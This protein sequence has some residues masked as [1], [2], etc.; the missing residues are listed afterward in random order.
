MLGL[1]S[2]LLV[3][4]LAIGCGAVR[5]LSPFRLGRRI[6]AAGANARAAE[7]SGVPVAASSSI[8]HML[9]GLLA[10]IGGHDG[11]R[12]SWRSD[13]GVGRRRLAAALLPRA[14]ARRHAAFGRSGRGGRDRARGP[15]GDDDPQRAPGD[16]DRQLLAPA[17]PRR[18]PASR[19]ARSIAIARFIRSV[20]EC[21]G[22]DSVP[23]PAHR[24]VVR[25]RGRHSPG[26]SGAE[27][28]RAELPHRIQPLRHAAEPQRRPAGRL[29]AN[30]YAGRRP[31]EHRRRRA[32]RPDRH[33][34]RRDDGALRPFT[35][36]GDSR[37][38][39]DRRSAAA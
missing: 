30:G 6:L 14:G 10:A 12:A 35:S 4:A 33:H 38:A 17:L 21:R 31:N 26:R 7:M 36:S 32:G 22:D 15:A 27:L 23:P 20:A 16:A 37:R 34:L 29:R 1:V 18:H 39:R 9:S 19:R 28:H 13:A 5:L 25:P 3:I 2:P 11:G 8:S 24:R